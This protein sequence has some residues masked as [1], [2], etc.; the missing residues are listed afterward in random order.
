M[1]TLSLNISGK[2]GT[3]SVAAGRKDYRPSIESS[4]RELH[5]GAL[6]PGFLLRGSEG[7]KQAFSLGPRVCIGINLA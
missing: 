7:S 1:L 4:T 5:T 3:G 2:L 6:V